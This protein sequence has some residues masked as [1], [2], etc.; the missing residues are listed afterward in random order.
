[1]AKKITNKF[2]RLLWHLEKKYEQ[3]P[4]GPFHAAVEIKKITA[5]PTDVIKMS[6]QCLGT[7]FAIRVT[8][9]I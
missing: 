9:E 6:L 7:K 5:L 2:Q 1:M 4:L 8:E 3:D